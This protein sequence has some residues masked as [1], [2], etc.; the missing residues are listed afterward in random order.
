MELGPATSSQQT[1]S[2]APQ[3]D[4]GS[5]TEVEVEVGGGGEEGLDEEEKVALQMI[6]ELLN[7]N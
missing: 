6:E 2:K 3:E 7:T 5:T 1:T 4:L